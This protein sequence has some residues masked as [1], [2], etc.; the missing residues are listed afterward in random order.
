MAP[1]PTN[2]AIETLLDCGADPNVARKS[3][4]TA[5]SVCCL[6]DLNPASQRKRSPTAC[7]KTLVLGG[8]T[9]EPGAAKGESV[10]LLKHEHLPELRAWVDRTLLNQWELLAPNESRKNC[11]VCGRKAKSKCS[12][13]H[14]IKYWLVREHPRVCGMSRARPFHPTVHPT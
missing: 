8:A 5:I 3:G 10:A 2:Q 9:E 7:L 14:L 11:A 4:V 6:A 1:R 13:C 12:A